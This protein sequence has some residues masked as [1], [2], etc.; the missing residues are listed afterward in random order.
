MMHRFVETM[1]SIKILQVIAR[2]N[3]GGPA[4]YAISLS[5]HFSHDPYQTLLVCGNVSA[6]EGDMGYFAE[7][8]GISPCFL[9]GLGREI[10]PFKDIGSL[11]ALRQIIKAYNPQ[12]IHTHT[13]K[14]GTL[15]R[16]AGMSLN[17]FRARE[18]R[19]RLVH[20]FHGHVFHSY[21]GFLKTRFFICI[22]RFLARF[23]DKIIV[24]SPLQRY[25]ICSRFKI[26]EPDRVATIPLGFDFSH[27]EDLENKSAEFR[28]RLF[29]GDP[30]NAFWVGIVGRLTAV[31]NHRMFLDTA[32]ILKDRIKDRPIRFFVV[33]DGELMDELVAYSKGAG[34]QDSVVFTGWQRDTRPIYGAMDAFVL[35]SFNEGTPVTLIEAMAAGKPVAATEVGG[36][37]DLLESVEPFNGDGF[38]LGRHGIL[39]PAE[40][41]D[42]LAKAL[43]FLMENR[44]IRNRLIK[45]A[46]RFALTRFGKERA[47][48]D[49][50]SLYHDLLTTNLSRP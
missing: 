2:L 19:I 13:A 48:K 24:I 49:M 5:D 10:S 3:I 16:L 34:L 42:A 36:V 25:D 31:K 15:G 14:A 23:T 30:P 32:R 9:P 45:E 33:G 11:Q 46:R 4:K 28:N 43:V 47:E 21:F 50:E 12:I 37:P 18:N 22:E 7:E 39:V 6:R 20:T 38:S 8:K 27:L 41:S 17:L 26:S 29:P 44:E 35:T 1:N 40:K